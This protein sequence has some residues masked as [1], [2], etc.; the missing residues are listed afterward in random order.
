VTALCGA[1]NGCGG[2][3]RMIRLMIRDL[4]PLDARHPTPAAERPAA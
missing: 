3:H 2:C 1:G 4:G